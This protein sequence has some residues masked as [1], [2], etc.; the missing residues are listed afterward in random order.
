[1]ASLWPSLFISLVMVSAINLYWIFVISLFLFMMGQPMM[2]ITK[3][4][5]N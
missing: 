3:E 4:K 1:L 5:E 2:L